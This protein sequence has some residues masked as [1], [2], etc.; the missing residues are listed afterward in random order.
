MTSNTHRFRPCTYNENPLWIHNFSFLWLW[1]AEKCFYWWPIF[2]SKIMFNSPVFKSVSSVEIQYV[3]TQTLWCWALWRRPYG[4]T[5]RVMQEAVF[6]VLVFWPGKI[7]DKGGV[8][9][10]YW[11][12]AHCI[13]DD[14][15]VAEPWFLPSQ[16]DGGGTVGCGLD[17]AWRQ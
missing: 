9:G 16:P 4:S 7:G 14:A 17:A 12:A 11:A 5:S 2:I 3:H 13:V 10:S 15:N 6:V 8:G 1:A